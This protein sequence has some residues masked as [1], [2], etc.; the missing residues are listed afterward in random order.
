MRKLLAVLCLLA[1]VGASVFA[2]GQRRDAD[3]I[4]VGIVMKSY[5][6]PYFQALSDAIETASTQ[7]GWR[8]VRLGSDD[9]PIREAANIDALIQRRVDLMFVNN[10][11]P[12]AVIPA[13]NRA[14]DA[15][16]P[17]IA[18][19]S[20]VGPGA[21]V[22][23]TVYSNNVENGRAV[24]RKYVEYI[25]MDTPIVSILLSGVRGNPV[26]LE[27]RLGLMAGIIGARL[28]LSDAAADTAAAEMERQL[29]TTGRAENAAARFVIAG[30][31]W[32]NWSRIDGQA[33]GEDLITANLATLN[34]MMAENDEMNLGARIALVNAGLY[35]VNIIAAADGSRAAYHLIR[36]GDRPRYIA[37]GENSPVKVGQ[38]AVEIARQILVDG[39][40][41]DSFPAVITTEA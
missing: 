28:G 1:L 38:R 32:G 5:V 30:Q 40:H 14:A 27:R 10:V 8:V 13:L 7:L 15:G 12:N 4:E 17:V 20:A 16:I 9:D 25:G 23:T 34:L 33:A 2:G 21:R 39:A 22:V 36:S 29:V 41:P 3:Q 31:G 18:I 11:D 26:G 6:S 37:T 35:H 24:G 19:D